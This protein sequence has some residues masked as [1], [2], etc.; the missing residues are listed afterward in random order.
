M[1]A[2]E[3]QLHAVKI[4][5]IDGGSRRL[6]LR[7]CR[8]ESVPVCFVHGLPDIDELIRLSGSGS[9]TYTALDWNLDFHVYL[10]IQNVVIQ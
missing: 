4:K 7:A 2:E 10:Q 9:G 6:G 5:T 1:G 8:L 3:Y